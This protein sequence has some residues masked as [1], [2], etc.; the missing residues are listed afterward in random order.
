MSFDIE[1]LIFANVPNAKEG[2]DH[3]NM[4]KRD[5]PNIE[6]QN[7]YIELVF[8][9]SKPCRALEVSF[10]IENLML[11]NIPNAKEGFFYNNMKERDSPNIE[12]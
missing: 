2:F 11:G 12:I 6:N 1:N 9:N 8:R 5:S 4:K 7:T 10:D 3:K